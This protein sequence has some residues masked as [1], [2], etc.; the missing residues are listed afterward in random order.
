MP[1]CAVVEVHFDT[2]T[3]SDVGVVE[4]AKVIF[5]YPKR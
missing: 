2:E 4:P 5:D 3:W 1:T